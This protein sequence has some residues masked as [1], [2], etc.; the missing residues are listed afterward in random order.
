M[1]LLMELAAGLNQDDYER[2]MRE[3][4]N[5]EAVAEVLNWHEKGKQEAIAGVIDEDEER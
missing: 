4:S 2:F 1:G 3:L 5:P